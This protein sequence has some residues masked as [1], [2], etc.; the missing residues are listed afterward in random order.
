MAD[1]EILKVQSDDLL[2]KCL[3]H[4]SESCFRNTSRLCT[5][6]AA[7]GSLVISDD[8]QKLAEYIESVEAKRRGRGSPANAAPEAA[9]SGG[10]GGNLPEHMVK[11]AAPPAQT[12]G[13]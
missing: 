3:P 2:Q 11:A 8:K 10:V 6:R 9:A 13:T 12:S 5:S 7:A 1:Y 4:E